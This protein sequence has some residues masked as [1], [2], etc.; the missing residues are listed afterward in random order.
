M[1][2]SNQFAT[3]EMEEIHQESDSVWS[4]LLQNFGGYGGWRNNSELCTKLHTKLNSF[5]SKHIDSAEH[6]EIV[7][8]SLSR[9]YWL[10][11]AALDWEN[12]YAGKE[13]ISPLSVSMLRGLQWRL[14]MAY[15]AFEL[16]CVALM[17]S[18]TLSPKIISDFVQK[19]QLK[20]YA[21]PITSPNKD[22]AGLKQWL[23]SSVITDEGTE[24][25]ALLDFLGLRCGDRKMFQSW[26]LAESPVDTWDGSILLAKAL[27]NMSAHGALS[28]SKVGEL[29]LRQPL[30]VL[31]G[32]LSEVVHKALQQ[33]L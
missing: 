30:A 15:N 18:K 19:C 25:E 2:E 4:Q 1:E 32:D 13:P 24:G 23:D 14:V 27:R 5:S 29:G 31:P 33:L 17:Q 20:E 6:V 22:R 28:A 21:D 3:I 9:G 12:P 16:I 8:Y 26:V 11:K 7:L 10:M